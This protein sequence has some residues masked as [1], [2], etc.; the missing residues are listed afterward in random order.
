MGCEYCEL[1]QRQN[2][3]N[4]V[5]EDEKILVAVKDNIFTA[6]Q[7]T[8]FPKEHFT[9][10][11]MVPEDILQKCFLMA[12]KLSIAAFESLSC[13]GTNILIQNGVSA[14]QKTPH[15]GLEIIP[16]RENDGLNLQWPPKQLMEDEIET[17][18][19]MLKEEGEKI[20]NVGKASSTLSNKEEGKK[21]EAEKTIF[22]KEEGKD[23][24]LIKSLRRIP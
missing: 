16:R 22:K 21:A 3:E 9:I 10:L 5:Y 11:E 2:K 7:I 14:G 12:N 19:L 4:I 15:F 17:V 23:N 6:G 24:Y 8:V 1:V 18:F 20:V 13:Q